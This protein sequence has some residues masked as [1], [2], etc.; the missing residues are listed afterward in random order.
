MCVCLSHLQANELDAALDV[1]KQMHEAGLAPNLV[2]YNIL[3]DVHVKRAQWDEAIGTLD[4]IRQQVRRHTTYTVVCTFTEQQGCWL[5]YA[6]S[7]R[8]CAVAFLQLA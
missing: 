1:F 5:Q 6:C 7:M 8:L 4:A 2:T 3:I